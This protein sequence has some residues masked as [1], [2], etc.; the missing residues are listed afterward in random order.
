[1]SE[2]HNSQPAKEKRQTHPDA[3]DLVDEM[4]RLLGTAYVDKAFAAGLAL[5]REYTRRQRADPQAA[6]AWLQAQRLSQPVMQVSDGDQRW[7]LLP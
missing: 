4:R 7:G 2:Q 5:E 3:A 1:V 6:H